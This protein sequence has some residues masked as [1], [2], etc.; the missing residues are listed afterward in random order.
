MGK[1]S[2]WAQWLMVTAGV[3]LSPMVA[4]FVTSFLGRPRIRRLW[5]RQGLGRFRA[6]RLGQL[7]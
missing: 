1:V 7:R 5:P 6:G 3:M 4:L 2:I